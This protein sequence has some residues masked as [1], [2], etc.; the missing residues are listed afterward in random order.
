MSTRGKIVLQLRAILVPYRDQ[1][2]RGHASNHGAYLLRAGRLLDGLDDA[3]AEY[4][5]LQAS[6]AEARADLGLG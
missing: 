4:P 6:L 1:W 3:V 5:D 2:L